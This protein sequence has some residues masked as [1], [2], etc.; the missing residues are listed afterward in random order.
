VKKRA[1]PLPPLLKKSSNSA[2]ENPFLG[3]SSGLAYIIGLACE[4][5]TTAIIA[6]PTTMPSAAPACFRVMG[7]SSQKSAWRSRGFSGSKPSR[8]YLSHH[9]PPTNSWLHFCFIWKIKSG[10]SIVLAPVNHSLRVSGSASFGLARLAGPIIAPAG[11]S[12]AWGH[13]QQG[14][15][16]FRKPHL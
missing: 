2:L 5:C 4:E 11:W 12:K 15:R 8:E 7:L 10:G 6:D 3:S 9:P 13:N 1:S 16:H 14:T